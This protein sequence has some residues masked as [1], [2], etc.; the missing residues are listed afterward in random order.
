[1]SHMLSIEAFKL[2]PAVVDE[3]KLKLENYE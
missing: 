2:V 1:M 3:P